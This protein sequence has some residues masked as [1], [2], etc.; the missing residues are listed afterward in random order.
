MLFDGQSG[1]ASVEGGRIFSVAFRSARRH[2][3]RRDFHHENNPIHHPRCCGARSGGDRT[4]RVSRRDRGTGGH[5]RSAAAG[6]GR[7]RPVQPG[8]PKAGRPHGAGDGARGR[9]HAGGVR[10][11][12]FPRLSRRARR[13][14]PP[15]GSL[16]PGDEHFDRRDAHAQRARLLRIPQRQGRNRRGSRLSRFRLQLGR[17]GDQRGGCWAATG[18]AADRHRQGHR[19][20]RLQLL[21]AATV[22]PAL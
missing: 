14:R 4:R 16:H 12:G 2:A 15:S 3:S 5:A 22:R 17:R 18:V 13:S 7:A 21:C 9:R 20:D 6:V 8:H 19:E 1:L 10:Q 11:H